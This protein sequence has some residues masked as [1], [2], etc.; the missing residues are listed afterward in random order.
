MTQEEALNILKSGQSAFLTGAAGSGKTYVLRSYINYLKEHG[1]SVGVTAST[2]IAATHIGGM[3]IHSWA[4]IGIKD[5]LTPHD[6]D[7]LKDRSQLRNRFQTTEILIIDEISM[8]HHFRLDL[9][10]QVARALRDNDEPFGGMQVIFAGDFF[11]LPPVSRGLSEPA[12]F[13][14]WSDA[15][16]RLTPAI[17]YLEE[18]YRQDDDEYLSVLNAIRDNSFD[19]YHQE[20]LQGRMN[21][22]PKVGIEPT[23]LHSHNANVDVQNEGELNKI[24]GQMYEYKMYSRGARP[25]VEAL[26]KSCLA[27]EILKLKVG[28]KVMFVKNNFDLGYVNGTLGVVEELL[29]DTIKVRTSK[30]VLINVPKDTWQIEDDGKVKAEI[31]QFPLRLAWAITIHKSQGMSLDAAHIDLSKSFEPGMGYVALSRVKTLGGLTLAG[32]NRQA[33]LVHPEVLEK[34]KQFRD[35]SEKW[36]QDIRV[37]EPKDLKKAHDYFLSRIQKSVK[38]KKIDTVTETYELLMLGKSSK[39]IAK[40]RGLKRDTI[41][42]HIEKIKD[43]DPFVDLSHI[44]KEISA[45]KFAKI[46]NEFVKQGTQAGGERPLG[47]IKNKL[48]ASVSYDDLKLVRIFL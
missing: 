38:P 35:V 43:Q 7:A 42:S 32:I 44:R 31:S 27:P 40:E 29:Y 14:Y 11:Q 1:V 30:D 41:L 3:T 17:C 4:G 36:S 46:R 33:L 28:A 22:K 10:D 20:L 5:Y 8:L 16:E 24:K 18:Q 26:I 6:I 9:V 39:E 2:G 21:Q 23:V 45:T 47:P 12:R 19:I 25:L 13:A 34:D 37:A 48:G 15:W